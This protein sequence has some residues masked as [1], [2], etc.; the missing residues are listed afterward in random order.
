MILLPHIGASTNQAE[1]N[2]AVMA[3]N[4]ITDFLETGNIKNSVNFPNVHLKRTT[5]H[6]ISTVSY[7]HLRAHETS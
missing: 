5:D 3:V 4:Q 2:C 6:R 1:E 7:T